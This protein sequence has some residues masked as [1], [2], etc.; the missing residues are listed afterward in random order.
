LA[1]GGAGAVTDAVRAAIEAL[2]LVM[3]PDAPLRTIQIGPYAVDLC[4]GAR[5]L[6]ASF[7]DAFARPGQCGPSGFRIDILADGPGV[8]RPTIL[9]ATTGGDMQFSAECDS[10]A[11]WMGRFLPALH[12]LHRPLR[13]GAYW[14]ESPAT[15]P[16]WERSRPLL[17]LVQAILHPTPWVALHGAAI[18]RDGRAVLL[19]GRGK[20][21]KTSLALAA[22]RAGW[23]Y[24]GDDFV[25]VRSGPSPRIAP[26]YRTARLRSDMAERFGDLLHLRRE[27]SDDEGE[28]RHE[29]AFTAGDNGLLGGGSLAAIALIE[30]N[31][32]ATPN[33]TQVSRALVV[34]TLA[35][36]TTVATPGYADSRLNKLFDIVARAPLLRFDPGPDSD[37]ALDVLAGAIAA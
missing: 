33:R 35:T 34:S 14:T 26:L 24:A 6:E 17:P 23:T 29:L 28:I 15:V 27:I 18:C 3:P 30:R 12:M 16:A 5:S 37:A 22:L 9:P 11:L 19:A 20:A 1:G 4:F 36:T 21:G 32:A 7:A 2:A 13:R 10:Y 25:L 31:G 8:P